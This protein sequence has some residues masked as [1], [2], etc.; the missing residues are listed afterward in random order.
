[1]TLLS[2]LMSLEALE[3]AIADGY[4]TRRMHR[5]FDLH[6]LNYTDKAQFENHWTDVTRQCRG[7]IVRPFDDG[8]DAD[9]VARP[10]KK[11]FNYGQ[12]GADEIRDNEFALVT[13][14]IDGSLGIV[15]LTPDGELNVATRGSFHSEQAEWATAWLRENATLIY[16]DDGAGDF[17]FRDQGRYTDLFEIV[18]PENR[19]VLNY[20]DRA[21]LVYLASVR[22]ET[23]ATFRFSRIGGA[24]TPVLGESLG[25]ALKLHAEGQRENAEGL[26]VMT[27]DGRAVKLKQEDYL[28]KHRARFN[29]TPRRIWEAIVGGVLLEDFVAGLPD[30]FH[31]AAIE[32]WEGIVQNAIGHV[33]KVNAVSWAIPKGERKEQARYINA[34]FPH[35]AAELF[36]VLDD[37]RTKLGKLTAKA[38]EPKG[39][40]ATRLIAA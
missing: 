32:T 31:A 2:S 19:I 38:C 9:V 5:D 22:V 34:N 30:E 16:G 27:M 23:G 28:L 11:F 4:V 20:G 29:L 35:L 1:M 14:K 7:L 25:A 18:Y 6:I 40:E 8:R 17:F 21:E 26:V 3:Q 13:D 15:Y 36:A 12:A 33:A 37:D 39:A 10:F 24:R